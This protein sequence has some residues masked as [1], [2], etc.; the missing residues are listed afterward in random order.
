MNQVFTDEAEKL[1][2]DTF[3]GSDAEYIRKVGNVMKDYSNSN[4]MNL[5]YQTLEFP[6]FDTGYTVELFRDF[7][8]S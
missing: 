5:R 2:N 6:F 4:S 8:F 7:Q 1:I 3:V